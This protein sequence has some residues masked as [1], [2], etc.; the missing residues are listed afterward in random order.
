MPLQKP[1]RHTLRTQHPSVRVGSQPR[2][3]GGN[4]VIS[5]DLLL[6]LGWKC[7][8]MYPSAS[9]RAVTTALQKSATTE[10]ATTLQYLAGRSHRDLRLSYLELDMYIMEDSPGP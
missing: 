5:V 1:S 8:Q 7:Q 10:W 6:L 4:D 2:A 9:T 3:L